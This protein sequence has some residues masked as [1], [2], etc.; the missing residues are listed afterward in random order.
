MAHFLQ[1]F[2]ALRT[3][4]G[5]IFGFVAL[6]SLALAT[7]AVAQTANAS[8][9]AGAAYAPAYVGSETCVSCHEGETEAWQASHHAQAWRM[10]SDAV[11]IGAFQGEVFEHDGMRAQFDT[12]EGARTVTVREKDGVETVYTLHSVGGTFPLQHLILETGLGRLQSF[13]VV[14]DVQEKRWFHLYPEQDLPPQDAYHWSGAYKNWNA[15]CAECHATGFEKN[16]DFQRKRYASTQVEIGVGCEACHGPGQAHLDLVAGQPEA[17]Y[18]VALTDWGFSADMSEPQAAMEQCAGCHA[19]RE[20]FGDGNPL[21]GTAFADAYNLAMLRPGQY[22]ADGQILDE[23]Y[24]YGSFLQSKMHQQ[25]VT[26]ANCHT[27][28][29]GELLAEGDAI[30]TQCHSEAGNPDFPTLKLTDYQSPPHTHHAEGSE[31]AQC[32]NCHMTDQVYMGNDWR[33][34]HNFRVPRPDVSARLD[35]PDACTRCHSDQSAEWAADQVAGWFPN[36]RW[37]EPHYGDVLARGRA[38]PQAAAADLLALAQDDSQADLV[39]A[40]ALWLLGPGATSLNLQE[41]GAFLEDEDP[42]V[43]VGALQA[44]R[45]RAA[46]AAAPYLIQGLQD[47]VRAV[48]IAAARAIMS[49]PAHRL[50]ESLRGYMRQA[51]QTFGGMVRNQMDFAEAHLQMAGYAMVAGDT[52]SAAGALTEAVRIN[53]QNVQAWATLVRLTAELRGRAAAKDTLERALAFNPGDLTLLSLESQF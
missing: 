39:R 17:H 30:C 5:A 49:Q 22:H 50:P 42:Q 18:Q 21:P 15:R 16:Y 14:W 10:P 35:T 9:Q 52:R 25:G 1:A 43:R 51:F 38:N 47:D 13:D 28:H 11:L 46:V 36:G 6:V 37:T 26:C 45:S 44:L 4:A 2:L 48:R 41:I 53:P 19:R 12:L 23:V 33:R 29:S 24:V 40:S 34:D 7:E 27:P 32:V 20:A 3:P 8:D 31:G